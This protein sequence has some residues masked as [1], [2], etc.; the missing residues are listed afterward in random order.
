MEMVI[1]G[2]S[3]RKVDEITKAL[4]GRQVSKSTASDFRR[5]FDLVVSDDHSGL[6]RVD[7]THSMKG[8]HPRL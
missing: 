4:C 3:T 7:R 6:V 2:V 8:R 1:Q 5:R